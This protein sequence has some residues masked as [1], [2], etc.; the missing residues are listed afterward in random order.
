MTG[1]S[2]ALDWRDVRPPGTSATVLMPCRPSAQQR[3]LSLAGVPV[4]LSLQACIAG[5]LTW[6]MV[7]ADVVDPTRVGAALDELLASSARNLATAAPTGA[8]C[9]PP[10]STP[11]EHSRRVRLRGAM[12]DGTKAELESA[13]FSHGTR[14][15]QATVLGEKLDTDA[16]ETFF[17]SL[18]ISP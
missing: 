6:G 1:C 13:V 8:A 16:A 15:F 12:P 4:V 5:G 18:R 10:G 17:A 2:P 7:S 14:V 3:Q 11:N 9:A